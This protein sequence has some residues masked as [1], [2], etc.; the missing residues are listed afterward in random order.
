MFS[1]CRPS[2]FSYVCC[3]SLFGFVVLCWLLFGVWSCL[4]F[5]V[6]VQVVYCSFVGCC[7]LLLVVVCG[8]LLLLFVVVVRCLLFVVVRNVV[9]V[10]LL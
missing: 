8:L 4:L 10:C 7:S 3:A 2:L 6:C 1:F 5:V 9:S